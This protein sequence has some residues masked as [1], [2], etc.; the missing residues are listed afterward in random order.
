MDPI[1][2]EHSPYNA[3]GGA[4]ALF[5]SW[6]G[7]DFFKH[8][9][10]IIDSGRGV[11]AWIRLDDV[12][13]L[14]PG[15]MFAGDIVTEESKRIPGV[16]TAVGTVASVA[17]RVNGYWLK[18]LDEALGVTYGCRIDTSVSDLPRVM[19]CPGTINRKTGRMAYLVEPSV[20]V[21]KGL[22]TKLIEGTPK[23]ALIDPETPRGLA[24]GLPWQDVYPHLTR[25]A[26]VYLTFGQA[27]P[28]RHKVMWHTAKKLNEL[29]VSREEA[30]KALSHANKLRGKGEQLEPEQV[31]HALNTAYGA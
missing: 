6:G 14:L 12:P 31:E 10:I 15:F 5:G 23:T 19:R 25:T 24:R 9:P 21:Y 8:P 18:R 30:R 17:R 29:G 27:E 22:A 28:G 4:L 7:Q 11:Q 3:L 26:Q 1:E 16:C 20:H 13:M 2:E